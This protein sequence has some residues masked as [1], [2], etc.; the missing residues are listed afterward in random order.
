MS[1]IN[2]LNKSVE[3]LIFRHP[4]FINFFK[5]KLQISFVLDKKTKDYLTVELDRNLKNKSYYYFNQGCP[6]G[7]YILTN[8]LKL[9]I[10]KKLNL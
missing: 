7:K 1:Y 2:E 8:D 6:S 4:F 3:K 5:N 10:I 9:K